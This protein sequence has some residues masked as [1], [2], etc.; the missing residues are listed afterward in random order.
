MQT[1]RVEL[2]PRSYD[3]AIGHGV[4]EQFAGF[5]RGRLPQARQALVVAD[6]NTRGHAE[7]LAHRV[8]ATA[9]VT[10]PAG[11]E[12]KSLAIA[13][14]LYGRLADLA[15]D[16][17]SPVVAVGGGVVGDLAGFVAATYNRGLPL[18]MVPTTLLAMVDS[19]VGGKV[20]VNLPKG[21]NLIGSFHQPAGVWI[22]TACLDTLPEREFRSGLAEVVKY[23]VILDAEF[24]AF[25]E[26][27]A[28]KVLAR[29]PAAV[30]HVVTRSCELKAR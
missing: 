14:D 22:D 19:S 7:R 9:V 8:G 27:N 2:G 16:R 6:A 5:V 4:E 26:A 15:A 21:K 20:G 3:I 25:L 23:G 18:V 24:L 17:K 29:D 11:E 12:S 28:D 1:L 10:V 30:R 13:A